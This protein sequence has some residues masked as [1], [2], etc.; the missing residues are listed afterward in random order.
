MAE[1]SLSDFE[2]DA[3]KETANIGAGSASISLSVL[4]GRRVNL[5]VSEIDLVVLGDNPKENFENA[6]P[7]MIDCIVGIFSTI[8]NEFKGDVLVM[9]EWTSAISLI[10]ILL[11]IDKDINREPSDL[12]KTKLKEIGRIVSVSYV[13]AFNDFF[14]T[15][16]QTSSDSDL[17]I[18]RNASEKPL[19]SKHLDKG[20]GVN[21]ALLLKTAFTVENSDVWGEF[22]MMLTMADINQIISLIKEKLGI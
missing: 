8:S 13:K 12:D 3:L 15:D 20:T 16:I 22:N 7:G 21:A 2:R 4:L 19:I 9:L 18:A 6:F 11:N 1:I 10:N 14:G 17:L 5:L